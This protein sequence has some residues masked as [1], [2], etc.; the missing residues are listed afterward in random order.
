[1]TKIWSYHVHLYEILQVYYTADCGS[2]IDARI[3]M[4]N[5]LFNL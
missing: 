1:M 3:E 2:N 4:S 5:K